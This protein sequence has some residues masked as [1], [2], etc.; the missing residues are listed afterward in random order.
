MCIFPNAFD[1]SQVHQHAPSVGLTQIDEAWIDD[2]IDNKRT[3]FTVLLEGTHDRTTQ[4][5]RGTQE[6]RDP[7]KKEGTQEKGPKGDPGTQ[8][9]R[10]TRTQGNKKPRDP[11]GTQEPRDP[12]TQ[13]KQK[14][15][16]RLE[17]Y[18]Y[19]RSEAQTR[20]K[21]PRIHRISNKLLVERPSAKIHFE[22]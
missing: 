16:I 13:R 15:N 11:G 1:K 18:K 7:R 22:I 12:G 10:N 17:K 6:P 4:L 3:C 21:G 20:S 5:A 2:Q 9:P 14:P 8:G 19:A